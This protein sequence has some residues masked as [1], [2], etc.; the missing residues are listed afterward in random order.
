MIFKVTPGEKQQL[1][2]KK[3]ADNIREVLCKSIH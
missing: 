3:D 2:E 1:V